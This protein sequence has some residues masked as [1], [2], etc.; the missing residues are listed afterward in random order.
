MQRRTALT[1]C[2][3]ALSLLLAVP[4]AYAQMYQPL[5]EQAPVVADRAP[6]PA[7]ALLAAGINVAYVPARLAL[8][9]VG[10][11]LSGLTGWLTAGNTDAAD[12]VWNVLSGSPYLTP[13]MLRGS[14][15]FRF[16][17]WHTGR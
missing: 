6:S 9:S 3:L 1:R 14:E 5:P 13:N 4:G 17:P 15:S 11:A 2:V 12:D 16:G 10:I 8:S 7:T